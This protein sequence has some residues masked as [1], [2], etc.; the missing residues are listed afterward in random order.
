MAFTKSKNHWSA[1]PKYS[2][3]LVKWTT[4]VFVEKLEKRLDFNLRHVRFFFV[5]GVKGLL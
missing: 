2:N 1:A 4:L 5:G 3:E